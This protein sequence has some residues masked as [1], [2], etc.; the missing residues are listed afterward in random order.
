M[1]DFAGWSMPVR[2]RSIL[3]EHRAVRNAAGVFDISHMGQFFV[4]GEEAASWLNGLLTNDAEGLA[5]GEGQ[6]TLLCN[7][8]GGVIDDLI[9][10]RLGEEEFFMVVNAARTAEDFRWLDGRR[11]VEVMIEDRSDG[12]A[13]LAVQG[14]QA[15]EVYSRVT[16]GRTL[17]Q[18][19]HVEEVSIEGQGVLVCRTGYTGEDGFEL[20]CPAE[21]GAHWFRAMIEGGATPCGLGARDTLRLEV[22]YPLNGADL[23]SRHTPLE[24]GL[25]FAVDLGGADFVG[26]AKLAKQKEEGVTRRLAA[27]RCVEPGPPVRSGCKVLDAA[28]REAGVLTSGTLSPSLK[29]GIGLAYLPVETAKS[30]TELQIEVRGRRIPAEVVKKPFYKRR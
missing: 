12:M 21:A 26:R 15:P 9:L 2:Y 18:R 29:V 6:Y 20:F 8:Q 27:I 19:N 17:P 10:Y 25:G 3:E 23:S 4:S 30:G 7:E 16:G 11:S 1:V 13:G 24:A 14:R 22:C 5:P 28:G